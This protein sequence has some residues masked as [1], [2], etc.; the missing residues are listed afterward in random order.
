[1]INDNAGSIANINIPD[2]S[3]YATVEDL[4]Q[5]IGNVSMTGREQLE[6]ALSRI[7]AN[8]GAINNI[9][10]YDDSA[11]RDM[12]NANTGAIASL[13]DMKLPVP[14]RATGM[15]TLVS[16]QMFINRVPKGR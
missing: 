12:I 4:N 2:L 16:P 10:S 5:G 6:R 3:E 8:T 9:P 7:D 15:E 14:T 11:I 1:M 13:P